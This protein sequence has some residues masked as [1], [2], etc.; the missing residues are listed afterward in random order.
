MG[1]FVAFVAGHGGNKSPTEAAEKVW[2]VLLRCETVVW[3]TAQNAHVTTATLCRPGQD[4]SRSTLASGSAL[5][6]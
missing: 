1:R 6:A 3:S 2:L 4:Q 5:K